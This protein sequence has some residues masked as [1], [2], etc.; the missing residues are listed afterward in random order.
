MPTVMKVTGQIRQ[1]IL[2][3]PKSRVLKTSYLFLL[4]RLAAFTK[5]E[6]R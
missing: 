5:Y 2:T 3:W 1:K 6:V 4:A